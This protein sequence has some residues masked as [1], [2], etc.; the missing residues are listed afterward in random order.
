[1]SYAGLWLLLSS[2][3]PVVVDREEFRDALGLSTEAAADAPD[4]PP[5]RVWEAVDEVAVLLGSGA[6]IDRGFPDGMPAS[7]V[8]RGH[9]WS[10][11]ETVEVFWGDAPP[12]GAEVWEA[13]LPQWSATTSHD[14][15][16]APGVDLVAAPIQALLTD[17]DTEV[18]CVQGVTATYDEEGFSAAAITAMEIRATGLPMKEQRRVRKIDITFDRPHAVIAIARGGAWDGIPLFHSWVTPDERTTRG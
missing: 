5:A 8:E 7:E 6:L 17:D 2:L 9:A 4:V 13:R 16:A 3:G 15:T 18:Q 1:M 14:L 12:D 11:Y 10:S